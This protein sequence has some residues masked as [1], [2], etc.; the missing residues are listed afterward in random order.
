MGRRESKIKPNTTHRAPPPPL[1]SQS[2]FESA[3]H[4]IFSFSPTFLGLNKGTLHLHL[5]F[6]LLRHFRSCWVDCVHVPSEIYFRLPQSAHVNKHQSLSDCRINENYKPCLCHFFIFLVSR[7]TTHKRI[8]SI[9]KWERRPSPATMM[10]FIHAPVI[11]G[12]V[13]PVLTSDS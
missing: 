6:P 11:I 13:L 8:I 7:R 10:L 2:F 12:L 9:A 1:P 4:A 5:S 3:K